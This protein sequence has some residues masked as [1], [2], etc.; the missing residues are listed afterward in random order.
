MDKEIVIK[1]NFVFKDYFKVYLYLFFCK[2]IFKAILVFYV[3]LVLIFIFQFGISNFNL[4][5]L[6]SASYL[7]LLLFPIALIFAIYRFTKKTLSNIKLKENINIKFNSESFEDIGETF[8]MKY[9]WKDIF[10]IVEKRDWFLIYITNDVA[11]V[12]RKADL[13]DNQYNE[14]KELFGS[15]NIKKSLK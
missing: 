14:L 11:K 8:N 15:L 2:K 7:F 3:I 5:E 10:K 9:F 12:I 4:M 1:P 6:F 13:K